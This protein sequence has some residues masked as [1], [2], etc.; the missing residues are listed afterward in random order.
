MKRFLILSALLCAAGTT[1]AAEAPAATATMRPDAEGFIRDW[2]MF[3]PIKLGQESAGASYI[4]EDQLKDEA[5]LKPKAGEKAKAEGE[6][7]TWKAIRAKDYFFDFNELLGKT[8]QDV[9]GY[10]VAYVVC[11]K[12]MAGL[13]LL[14]GGND[15]TRIYVNGREV[16]KFLDARPL[17][18]DADKAENVTLKAGVNTIV[19]K[20][21]NELN[22]WQGCLRFTDK[23]AKPFT[24]YTVKLAP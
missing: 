23:D 8:T 16:V 17:E 4:V 13:N 10:M 7:I 21:I 3:A 14:A 11:E 12:E 1:F 19:F 15:Q 6:E 20:V 2:L 22:N 24:D 18:K 9:A 5:E